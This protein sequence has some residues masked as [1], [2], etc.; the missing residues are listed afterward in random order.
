MAN[1]KITELTE[2]V[3]ADSSDVLA[4]VDVGGTA[5]TKKITVANLTS[6]SSGLL[7]QAAFSLTN[8]D[9]VKLKYDDSPLELVAAIADKIIVPVSITIEA[10]AGITPDTS[11]TDLRCGWDPAAST[12]TKY[13][14]GKRN[15]MEGVSTNNVQ[16]FSGGT[17]ASAG[18]TGATTI[19]N[20]ALE[21]WSSD[22]FNGTFTMNV[23]VTY[24][25]ITV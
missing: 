6:G 25:T 16:I 19:V 21:L 13:W 12:S 9:V 14:D 20:T 7:T 18:V 4:I 15:Y 1:K 22:V 17:P 3:T 24:Y 5:E 11:T 10:I 23:Y 8:A 2:L